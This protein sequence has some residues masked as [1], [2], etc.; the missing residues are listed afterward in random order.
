VIIDGEQFETRAINLV[1][2]AVRKREFLALREDAVCL[3]AHAF[4]TGLLRLLDGRRDACAIQ[5][6]D[7]LTL[8][9]FAE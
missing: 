4:R 2:R 3:D 7:P 8:A 6:P 9:G 5:E 1:V